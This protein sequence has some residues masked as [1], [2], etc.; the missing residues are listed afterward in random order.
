MVGR[1]PLPIVRL[2]GRARETGAMQWTTFA[3]GVRAHRNPMSLL[4]FVGVPR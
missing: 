4:R 1:G 3:H 2:S